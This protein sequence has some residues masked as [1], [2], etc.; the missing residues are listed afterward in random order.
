LLIS[1]NFKQVIRKS[2]VRADDEV[3]NREVIFRLF[4]EA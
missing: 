2:F 4:R 3:S 1:G